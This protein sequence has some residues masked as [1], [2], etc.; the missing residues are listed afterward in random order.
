MEWAPEKKSAQVYASQLREAVDN[1]VQ[2]QMVADV[3]VGAFLSGGVDSA[4]IVTL[5][6]KHTDDA[7]KTFSV[8]FGTQD[9]DELSYAQQMSDR[10]GTDHKEILVKKDAMSLLPDIVWHSDEP[11]ADPAMLPVY[12]LAEQARK[13][14]TVALTGDGGD[15]LFAGYE[16]YKFLRLAQRAQKVPGLRTAMKLGLKL[17]PPAALTGVFKYAKA[18]GPQGIQRAQRLLSAKTPLDQYLAI[19]AIFT[20]DERKELMPKLRQQA[21]KDLAPYFAGK[22]V[23]QGAT[24][25]EFDVQL[26]ENMLMKTDRMT[27][28]HS[29]EARV[30]LLDTKVLE[31]ARKI[32]FDLRLH[33]RT[34]KYIFRRAMTPLLPKATAQRKKQRF[35]VPIDRWLEDAEPL[36]EKMLSQQ[37]LKHK[38]FDQHAVQK[39]RENYKTAPLFYARQ[40]WT[41]LTFQL[42]YDQFIRGGRRA[43]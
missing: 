36:I 32:P 26:P 28:A 2:R 9:A 3:P 40:L 7:V 20:A 5:M 4:S 29:L 19:T 10:L 34:E 43:P 23:L 15:E 6:S 18:M 21:E 17:I 33:G 41:L 30:P 27:L 8:G 24:K 39:I 13:K 38:F 16:Q 11:I 25:F 35:Y 12:V 14:V 37:M 31:V 22:D 42:W 1:A